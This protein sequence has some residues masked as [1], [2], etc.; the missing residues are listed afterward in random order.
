MKNFIVLGALCLLVGIYSALV[1]FGVVPADI[2]IKA[3]SHLLAPVFG[4]I[5]IILLSLGIWGLRTGQGRP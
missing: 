2:G 4:G 3:N 1:Y 5:G